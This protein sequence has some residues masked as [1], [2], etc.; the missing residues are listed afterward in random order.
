MPLR[1][2]ANGY[3]VRYPDANEF[4]QS[5]VRVALTFEQQLGL[6]LL[7]VGPTL[8]RSTLDGD[9]FEETLG[10]DLRVRRSFGA[11][12]AFDARVAYDDTDAGDLRFAY[13]DGS[14][15]QLRLAVQHA[16]SARVR[17][18]YDIE[19]SDRADPGVAASRQRWYVT[20]RRRLSAAWTGDAALYHRTSRYDEASVPRDRALTRAVVRRGPRAS[21]RVDAERRISLVGERLERR[22]LLLRQEPCGGEPKP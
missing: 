10:A 4:D 22:Y 20:Y 5:A 14:R 16:G 8:G 17:V 9:G 21:Q 2:D 1:L 19:H 15:R 7:A 6:W 18:G 12:F 3:F 11:G 13:L